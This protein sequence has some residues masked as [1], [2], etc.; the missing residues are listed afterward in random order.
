MRKNTY[1]LPE[2]LPADL[3]RM[4]SEV[5]KFKDGG[6][7]AAEFRSFRVPQGVYEER[8]EG[9]FMLRVR[10]PAGALLPHQMCTLADVSAEYGSGILHVTTRQDIQVHSVGID[11][12]FLEVHPNPEKALSDGPNSL[13][14]DRAAEIIREIKEIHELKSE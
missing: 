9:H 14:L 11:A 13:P 8:T 5:K 3:Q 4:R 2:S 1:T 7:S 6:S 12:L 10:L